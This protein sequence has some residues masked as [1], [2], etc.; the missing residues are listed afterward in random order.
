MTPEKMRAL[1]RQVDELTA[2]NET[3]SESLKLKTHELG[4][5]ESGLKTAR[6]ALKKARAKIKTLEG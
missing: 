2:K 6:N 5:S 4:I 1:Q 3:W